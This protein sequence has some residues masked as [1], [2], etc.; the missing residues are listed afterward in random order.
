MIVLLDACVVVDALQKRE[1]FSAGAE[2][3]L[4]LCSLGRSV[5]AITA[6]SLADIYY[7]SHKSTHS[8]SLS[9]FVLTKLCTLLDLLDAEAIDVRQAL[10]SA[11]S[12][13][14]DAVMIETAMRIGADCIV[15]RNK[16]DCA[17]SSPRL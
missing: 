4:R 10:S 7:L 6:K 8:S 16:K 11:T 12:D 15:T 3:I 13:F 5:G 14:E 1:P 9:R 17:N 2:E